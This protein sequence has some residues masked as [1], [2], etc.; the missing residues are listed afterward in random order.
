[1]EASITDQQPEGQP[2]EESPQTDANQ[3]TESDGSTGTTSQDPAETS[4]ASEP[5][6]EEHPPIAG[7]QILTE[8]DLDHLKGGG[9]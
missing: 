4:T 6:S 8:Q 3:P 7:K 1:M 5:E 9:I 2:S